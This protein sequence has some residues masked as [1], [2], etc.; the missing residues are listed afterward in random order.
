VPKWAAEDYAKAYKVSLD[1]LMTGAE[2]KMSH[3]KIIEKSGVAIRYVPL[4]TLLQVK[5]ALVEKVAQLQSDTLLPV[6]PNNEMLGLDAFALTVEDDSMTAVTAGGKS[7][8]RGNKLVFDPDLPVMPGDYCLAIVA[9]ED[10][11]VFRRYMAEAVGVVRLDA[12]NPAFRSYWIRDGVPGRIL[13][14][15][16]FRLEAL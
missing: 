8:P 2:H 4:V 7:F 3:S 9:G 13:A 11:P 5:Q 15:A 12:L 6:A 16:M 1:W 14:R 10:F